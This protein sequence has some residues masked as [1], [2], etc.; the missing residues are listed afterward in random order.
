MGNNDNVTIRSR[1]A[2]WTRASLSKSNF[3]WT[4]PASN[5][6]LRSMTPATIRCNVRL[7]VRYIQNL[8]Y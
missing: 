3:T 1:A 8:G 2:A 5:P 7:D 6:A 4:E